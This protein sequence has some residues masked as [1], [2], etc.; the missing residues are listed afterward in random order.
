[1]EDKKTNYSKNRERF[2]LKLIR[3]LLASVLGVLLI[4]NCPYCIEKSK[5]K[6]LDIPGKSYG[7]LHVQGFDENGVT[8]KE[9]SKLIADDKKV[10]E[11]IR[12]INEVDVIKPKE[13][14]LVDQIS[15]LN[16][17]GSFAVVLSD[18]KT[19]D[20]KTYYL[21]FFEDGSISFQHPDKKEM[22]YISKKNHPELLKELKSFFK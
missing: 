9:K 12:K 6:A 8:S 11:F 17:P 13:K 2:N 15:E 3:I 21:N 7:F 1:M 20:N 22:T 18:T 10:K 19:L 16:Y 5:S 14:E 4:I